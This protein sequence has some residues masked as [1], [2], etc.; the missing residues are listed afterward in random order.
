M[1][2][3]GQKVAQSFMQRGVNK[4]TQEIGQK[5]GSQIE[6]AVGSKVAN[7]VNETAT[8][9]LSTLGN[10]FQSAGRTYGNINRGMAQFGKGPIHE[11][12]ATEYIDKK[13]FT[14]IKDD[15]QDKGMNWA[16]AALNNSSTA[17]NVLSNM[18]WPNQSPNFSFGMKA[19]LL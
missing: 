10:L 12:V 9:T 7:A 18:S 15:I 16:K 11:E 8:S 14:P 5:A 3:I 19:N 2:I 13:V 4:A 17:R 1:N 6:K